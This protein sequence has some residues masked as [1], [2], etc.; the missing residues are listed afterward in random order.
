MAKATDYQKKVAFYDKKLS[1]PSQA[2]D[3][4]CC[5]NLSEATK[6]L[7]VE[8]KSDYNGF[9]YEE[10]E[11]FAGNHSVVVSGSAFVDGF[12][13]WDTHDTW[14]SRLH[15]LVSTEKIN[16]PVDEACAYLYGGSWRIYAWKDVLRLFSEY[17]AAHPDA[18]WLKLYKEGTNFIP[19]PKILKISYA[20]NALIVQEL[21]KE[22]GFPAV[23]ELLTCGKKEVGDANYFSAV[24]RLTGVDAA[25]YNA[26]VW[27]LI[28]ANN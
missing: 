23:M 8:Y 10:L 6:V 4:Y 22:K 20:I 24:Q 26:Y 1:A 27:K 17:A 2:I 11:G 3:F 7:G 28:K 5:D 18:D 19:P 9:F 16:R 12:N 15:H 21:E 25:G 13:D 14:H